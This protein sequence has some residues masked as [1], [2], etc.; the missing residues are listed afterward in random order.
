MAMEGC[1]HHLFPSFLVKSLPNFYNSVSIISFRE[2]HYSG[3]QIVVPQ[4][5]IGER[6]NT[7]GS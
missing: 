1:P 5:L 7:S 6:V 3:F 2:I 4:I